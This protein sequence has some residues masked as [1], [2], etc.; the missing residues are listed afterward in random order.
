MNRRYTWEKN[1]VNLNISSTGDR[2]VQQAG[3][4]S[5]AMVISHKDEG[6]Y[7]CMVTNPF[8][9]AVSKLVNLR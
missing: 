5:I 2:I 7:Q 8:G 4:G 1:G 9:V 6:V 3:E